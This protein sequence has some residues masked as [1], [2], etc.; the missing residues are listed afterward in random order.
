MSQA[1]ANATKDATPN[2][3]KEKEEPPL[4]LTPLEKILQH[5]GPIR[6]DGTDKFYGLEN[7]GSPPAASRDLAMTNTTCPTVR[8]Y[9]VG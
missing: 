8:E 4:E 3:K 2:K 9:M 6:E 1:S 5:A 7:V